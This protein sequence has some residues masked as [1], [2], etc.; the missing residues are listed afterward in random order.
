MTK[1][2]ILISK[3]KSIYLLEENMSIPADMKFL[4][5]S[6]SLS[7]VDQRIQIKSIS[8]KAGLVIDTIKKIKIT[9]VEKQ[10]YEL[11]TNLRKIESELS[12][13]YTFEDEVDVNHF[14][15]LLQTCLIGLPDDQRSLLTPII[16]ELKLSQ[17]L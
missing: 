8:M 4:K 9:S 1:E 6:D 11:A 10:M 13:Q 15:I 2:Q 17:L 12:Y 7:V 5:N 3:T 14:T 16:R